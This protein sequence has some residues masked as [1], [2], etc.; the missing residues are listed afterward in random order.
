M[1]T[2]SGEKQWVR[3]L[4]AKLQAAMQILENETGPGVSVGERLTYAHEIL[5]YDW[6]SGGPSRTR[7]SKYETDLLIYEH[8]PLAS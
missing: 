5:E 4:E 1:A 8:T 6:A 3:G 2:V 7:E